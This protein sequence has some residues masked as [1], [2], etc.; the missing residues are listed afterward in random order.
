MILL[1]EKCSFPIHT[2]FN[3]TTEVRFF[4]FLINQ[5]L[6]Y[7]TS[8]ML[9]KLFFFFNSEPKAF[10]IY[11]FG[12]EK[13]SLMS[14]FLSFLKLSFRKNDAK[15]DQNITCMLQMVCLAITSNKNIHL[16][17]TIELLFFTTI[18]F[19]QGF[20]KVIQLLDLLKET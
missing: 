8:E 19:T 2:I 7:T 11:H 4:M 15:V 6:E 10:Y 5:Q 3:T 14:I 12:L 17:P 20:S 16:T 18:I 9:F 13:C 1:L